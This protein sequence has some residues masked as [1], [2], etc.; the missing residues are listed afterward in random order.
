MVFT[1]CLLTSTG[2]AAQPSQGSL[3][4][5]VQP[6]REWVLVGNTLN[7]SIGLRDAH[8]QPSPAPSATKRTS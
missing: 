1:W 4:L 2:G 6:E 8:N 3:R 5:V 7:V